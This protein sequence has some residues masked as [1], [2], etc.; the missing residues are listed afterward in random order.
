MLMFMIDFRCVFFLDLVVSI[1][2]SSNEQDTSGKD[3]WSCYAL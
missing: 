3:V 2:Q 1:A